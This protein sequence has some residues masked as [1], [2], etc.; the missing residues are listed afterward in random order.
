[1]QDKLAE[2]LRVA[3]ERGAQLKR[4]ELERDGLKQRLKEAREQLRAGEEAQAELQEANEVR[5]RERGRKSE[6]GLNG[7]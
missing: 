4:V 1:M 3:E 2:A 7:L 5:E 6:D